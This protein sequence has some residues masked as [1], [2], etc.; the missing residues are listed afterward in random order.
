MTFHRGPGAHTRARKAVQS[1]VLHGDQPSSAMAGRRGNVMK[2]MS[3]VVLMV[4][5]PSGASTPSTLASPTPDRYAPGFQPYAV[6]TSISPA[7]VCPILFFRTYFMSR[8]AWLAG[9]IT[10][11]VPLAAAAATALL[12]VVVPQNWATV[13]GS[14]VAL[15]MSCQPT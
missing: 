3:A 14:S 5:G 2:S 10:T 11:F 7:H 13:D 6:S 9:D 4:S 15:T 8:S 1:C 12:V